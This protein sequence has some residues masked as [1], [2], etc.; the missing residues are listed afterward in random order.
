[1]QRSEHPSGLFA[2]LAE[3]DPPCLWPGDSVGIALT[4]VASRSPVIRSRLSRWR[5]RTFRES[6]VL[7]KRMTGSCQRRFPVVPR[8]RTRVA[9]GALAAFGEQVAEEQIETL[10]SD[11]L[12]V[13]T[14]AVLT[15]IATKLEKLG[16][17]R[18]HIIGHLGAFVI[19]IGIVAFGTIVIK[20]E[21][22]V[23]GAYH[24][25]FGESKPS[26]AH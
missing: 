15:G 18:H 19:L 16:G 14:Q 20:F 21:P 7:G 25:L 23:E 1:M 4:V 22:T 8:Y 26:A 17:Y 12:S 11:A 13:Q 10:R 5:A 2:G 24:W 3:I 9:E 6:H